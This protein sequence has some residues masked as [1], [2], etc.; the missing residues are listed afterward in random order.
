MNWYRTTQRVS[1]AE[2]NYQ[3]AY[4]GHAV[5]NGRI[6]IN[7]CQAEY[8][9]SLGNWRICDCLRRQEHKRL[10]SGVFVAQ[11]ITINL[12]VVRCFRVLSENES[13]ECTRGAVSI[14][15]GNAHIYFNDSRCYLAFVISWHHA[16][17]C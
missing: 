4:S 9:H 10:P 17:I 7:K 3:V 15:V 12:F 6:K 5:I 14:S 2:P 8:S 16:S 13:N 11:L 1:N